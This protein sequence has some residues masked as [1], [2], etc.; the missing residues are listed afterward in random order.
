MLSLTRRPNESI[1]LHTS[2]GVVK[3]TLSQIKGNQARIG[4]GAPK[5]ITIV[6]TEIDGAPPKRSLKVIGF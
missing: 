4:I 5:S 6:R 1:T 3:I 2:D